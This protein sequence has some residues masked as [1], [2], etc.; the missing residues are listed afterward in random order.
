MSFS[1]LACL[2]Y[3]SPVLFIN[4]SGA[5]NSHIRN[6]TTGSLGFLDANTVLF[7][8][9]AVNADSHASSSLPILFLLYSFS[10]FQNYIERTK[11]RGENKMK[12]EFLYSEI[13]MA[14]P[15]LKCCDILD[16]KP[17]K[18]PSNKHRCTSSS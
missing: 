8:G 7:S 4:P 15:W 2:S 16:Y 11:T 5:K 9:D 1:F 12:E 14:H 13:K 18:G 3:V 17:A 6:S 10:F